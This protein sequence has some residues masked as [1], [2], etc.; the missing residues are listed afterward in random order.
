MIGAV[1][2]FS[3]TILA[4]AWFWRRITNA[5]KK[6]HSQRFGREQKMLAAAEAWKA[7]RT[8]GSQ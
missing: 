2:W 5:D 4:C 8:V 1:V 7:S 6:I 3:M